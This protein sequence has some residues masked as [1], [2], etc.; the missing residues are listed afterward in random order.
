MLCCDFNAVNNVYEDVKWIKVC[1]R[2]VIGDSS[3]VNYSSI[4]SLMLFSFRLKFSGVP[5]YH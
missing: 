5:S 1:H 4:I 3:P 2:Q